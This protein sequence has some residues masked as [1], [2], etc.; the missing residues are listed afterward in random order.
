MRRKMNGKVALLFTDLVLVPFTVEMAR[1]ELSDLGI[2]N[3]VDDSI[4]AGV[5]S[6]GMDQIDLRRR[7]F[8]HALR[9][10][11]AGA[12]MVLCTCSSVSE[13]VA[14]VA[15]LLHVPLLRIDDAMVA[16]AVETGGD[17]GVVATVE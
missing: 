2:V 13:A 1:T 9:A 11:E 15:P 4:L 14:A 17:I 12:D 5:R 16:E 3:I 6:G 10:E 7:I 8:E